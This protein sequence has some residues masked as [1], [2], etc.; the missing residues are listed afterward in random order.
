MNTRHGSP[1]LS[2]P[3]L[4]GLSRVFGAGWAVRLDQANGSIRP[5]WAIRAGCMAV[6]CSG[7]KQLRA[8]RS[9]ILILVPKNDFLAQICGCERF[10]EL[11]R[12]WE[13]A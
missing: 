5:S 4:N 2:N 10:H 7:V 6:V 1:R 9:Q 8:I 3:E 11:H 13:N 12:V